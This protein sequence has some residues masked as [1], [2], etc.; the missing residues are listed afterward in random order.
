MK[1]KYEMLKYTDKEWAELASMLSDEKTGQGELLSRF[2]S[3]DKSGVIKNWKEMQKFSND[4]EINVDRAWNNLYGRLSE[5]KLI[6]KPVTGK[7]LIAGNAFLR[8]AAGFLILVSLGVASYLIFNHRTTDSAIVVTTEMNQKNL[9][10]TLPDGSTVCLNRNTSVA[11]GHNFGKT[12]R[13]ITLSGEAFFNIVPVPDVPFV[14]DAGKAAVMAKGTSFN[15]ISSNSANAVEVYVLTG[16]VVLSD[17]SGNRSIELEPGFIGTM[18]KETSSK[19]LN[20]DPNYLAWN[21]G[22]LVY[23]GQTLETVF[24]DLRKVYNMEI[25]ADD[26]GILQKTWTSPINDQPQE[27][28]IR[29]ICTSFNLNFTKVGNTYHLSAVK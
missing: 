14:V 15:V 4:K 8:M 20:N 25:V 22:I 18:K 16:K 21:T 11:Y 3:D 9:Q 12:D 28:I 27:T 19:T 10:V 24:N 26:P 17:N 5:D 13:K 6:G 2:V 7:K 23:D 29:L 1:T